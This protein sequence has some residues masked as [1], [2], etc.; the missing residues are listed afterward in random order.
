[1]AIE[2][3]TTLPFVAENTTGTTVIVSGAL[4]QSGYIYSVIVPA[5]SGVPNSDQI[6]AGQDSASGALGAGFYDSEEVSDS[7]IWASLSGYGLTSETDYVMYLVGSG[8]T[9]GLMAS[10]WGVAF[11]TPDI[12]AP[13]WSGSYPTLGTIYGTSGNFNLAINEAGSGFV[14]VLA[15][16]TA[17]PTASAIASSGTGGALVADTVA[18]ITVTG[19]VSETDYEAWA[20]AE[21][22]SSNIQSS[23]WYI[24]VFTTTDIT[25]PSWTTGWPNVSTITVNSASVNLKLNDA[26]SGYFVII[27]SGNTTPSAAQ[28]IA[29]TDSDDAAISAGLYGSGT[30]VAN[31]EKTLSAT[32]LQYSTYYTLCVTAKDDGGNPTASVATYSFRAAVPAPGA[33]SNFYS[34]KN[35]RDRMRR[36]MV[37]GTVTIR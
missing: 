7:G 30:L 17:E 19:L 35:V 36:G 5:A 29:G 8:Y 33:P 28:I 13:T 20:V 34:A 16:G 4:N 15:S 21:D 6:A 2:W 23:G 3:D 14:L 1:M 37:T 11:T 25:A 32:N 26:G 10:G 18:S 12:T 27:P 24:G 9:D 31:T 22:D